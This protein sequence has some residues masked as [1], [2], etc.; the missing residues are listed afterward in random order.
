MIFEELVQKDVLD[1]ILNVTDIVYPSGLRPKGYCRCLRP[2]VCFSVCLFFCM[3]VC[4]SVRIPKLVRAITREILFKS[5]W[6]L[7]GILFGKYFGQVRWWVLQLIK[8]T[9]NWP[10]SGQ[11]IF[12][13][14]EV[15]CQVIA[16][17]FV[18]AGTFT[19]LFDICDVLYEILFEFF[20]IIFKKFCLN[21]YAGQ[22]SQ[23][24]VHTWTDEVLFQSFCNLAG[25]L[26]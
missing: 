8:Y 23:G 9:H 2:F 19:K 16:L 17:A 25:I 21:G 10:K 5:L 11:D 24:H 3:P 20:T 7:T 15:I 6:H 12:C 4:L 26:R 13:N 1:H 14:S 18:T 22:Y